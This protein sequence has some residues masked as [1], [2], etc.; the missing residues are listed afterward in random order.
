MA[1]EDLSLFPWVR[2][3]QKRERRINIYPKSDTD[4]SICAIIPSSNNVPFLR[5]RE[6]P[7][8]IWLN[9]LRTLTNN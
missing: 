2:R 5:E 6:T 1:R 8:S 4:K 7:A 9:H 3:V